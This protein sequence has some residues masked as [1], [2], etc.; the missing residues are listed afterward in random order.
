MPARTLAQSQS[1]AWHRKRK[2]LALTRTAT[3]DLYYMDKHSGNGGS[4]NI[5]PK[6]AWPFTGSQKELRH[7]RWLETRQWW[8]HHCQPCQQAGL[9]QSPRRGRGRCAQR[10]AW[11]PGRACATGSHGSSFQ[12]AALPTQ[13]RS[14]SCRHKHETAHDVCKQIA[15]TSGIQYMRGTMQSDKR[16]LDLLGARSGGIQVHAVMAWSLEC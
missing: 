4:S 12:A 16:A 10:R 15:G 1:R 2:A 13:A 14:C 5:N 3:E 11:V 8:Q 9:P 6:L 7:G